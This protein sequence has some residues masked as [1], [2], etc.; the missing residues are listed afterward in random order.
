MQRLV[1]IG[2]A[3]TLAAFALAVPASAGEAGAQIEF[4][5][6]FFS[7]KVAG[8]VT[9]EGSIPEARWARAVGAVEEHN[10]SANSR[11]F[12]SGD[13]SASLNNFGVEAS[14]GT[15]KYICDNHADEMKGSLK[16]I[17]SIVEQSATKAKITWATSNST[18]GDRFDVQ[19]RQKGKPKWEN[20]FKGTK[21]KSGVF[22]RNGKPVKVK[23]NKTYQ[24]RVRSRKGTS[25][26]RQSGF[27]PPVE[28]DAGID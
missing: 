25:K 24:L 28:Y 26:I 2:I 5:D 8:P 27:S 16:V 17:P 1:R 6:N 4:G 9:V 15:F 19:F 23:P 10:I 3:G 21:R 20:W 13:P 22:G 12:R 18:T 14:A 7:P 11:L